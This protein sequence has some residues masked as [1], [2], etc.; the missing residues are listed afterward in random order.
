MKDRY[1]FACAACGHEMQFAPSVA[2]RDFGLKDAGHGSCSKC[3]TF[4]KLRI[5]DADAGESQRFD[6][7]LE[8]L[9]AEMDGV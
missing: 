1:D 4:L 5:N 3:K 6:E 7:Y 9:T 8:K 2:M